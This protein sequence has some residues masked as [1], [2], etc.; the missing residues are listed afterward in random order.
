MD[1]NAVGI[2]V[3]K[4]KSIV[5]ILRP[6]GEIVSPSFEIRHISNDICSLVEQIKSIDGDSRIVT[7]HTGRYMSLWLVSFLRLT[8]L[9][10]V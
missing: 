3:S 7:E 6:Y 1:M 4:G 10:V 2:D 9:Y 5:A 8:S